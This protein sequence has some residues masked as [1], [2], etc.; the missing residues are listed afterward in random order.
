MYQ[1]TVPQLFVQK[2]VKKL[3]FLQES[4]VA[5]KGISQ[6]VFRDGQY[7]GSVRAGHLPSMKV[8]RGD[9]IYRVNLIPWQRTFV[10]T[11]VTKERYQ[12]IYDMRIELEIVD[13][14][15][16]LQQCFDGHN[17]AEALERSF[18][19]MFQSYA[20]RVDS[21]KLNSIEGWLNDWI[22]RQQAAC[23]IRITHFWPHVRDDP[24]HT[25]MERIALDDRIT[26]L[27]LKVQ[28]EQELQKQ[29]YKREQEMRQREYERIEQSK[30]LAFEREE[31]NRNHMHELHKQLRG[32]AASEINEILRE[33]IRETSERGKPVGEVAEDAMKLLSAFHES[34]QH[35]IVDSTIEDKE[36]GAIIDEP[37]TST[38]SSS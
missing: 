33:R 22:A 21:A 36:T 35:G 7:Q 4:I 32:T 28:R 9:V 37:N 17:I 11:F 2:T 34:L 26:Q 13:P 23:G 16:V 1:T 24:K 18:Q 3:P 31:D 10:G 12:R 27:T 19:A 30:E 25:E 14:H 38:L 29:Q 20:S 15:L 5:I 8:R 6:E